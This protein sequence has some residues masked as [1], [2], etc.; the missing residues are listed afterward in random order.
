M[1]KRRR[2]ARLA[3]VTQLFHSG[4]I[5]I[6]PDRRRLGLAA[7]IAFVSGIFETVELYL[8][9]S[10]AVAVTSKKTMVKGHLGSL[11]WNLSIERTVL[12]GG[13]LLVALLLISVPLALLL[14]SLSSRSIVRMRTR[15]LA[16]YLAA[17]QRFRTTHREGL[18]Q[19]LIGEYCGRSETAVRQ[20]STF[21]VTL[22]MLAVV[23][24][25]AI[26]S[27]PLAAAG[28][29]VGL[30]LTS[31]VAAPLA[32]RAQKNARSVTTW[33]RAMSGQV[34]EMARLSE[35]IATFDV[36][37][38][39]SA[40]VTT[41]ITAGAE[42]L[43]RLRFDGRISPSLHLYGTLGVVLGL[44]AVFAAVSPSRLTGLAPLVLLLVRAL[45][46]V[47]QMLAATQGASEVAPFIEQIELELGALEQ[48]HQERDG[49][50][51]ARFAGLECRDVGFA[52]RNGHP[53]LEHVNLT[54]VAGE[55][56]GIVGASGSGKT[57]LA[58]LLL[59][60]LMPTE[61]MLASG[62]VPLP[63]V[64]PASW[65]AL[66]AFVPQ[67][68]KLIYGTV[69]DNIR[70]FRGGY[71]D[72]DVAGAARRAHLHGDIVALSEGYRTVIGPGARNLSGGQRQRLAIARALLSSPQLLVLDEPTSALDQH[73][74]ILISRTLHEL[75]GSMTIVLIAHRP[76]TIEICDRV[77]RV[78]DKAVAELS[79]TAE[80][81]G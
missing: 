56:V 23:L 11:S 16:A 44:I 48:H 32:R 12:F 63:E 66:S 54:I 31:A 50:E 37:E 53:V 17:E 76:A 22:C 57:S 80:R 46:Y 68:T 72:D 52:Y 21:C 24:V 14:A 65:A 7:L 30:A 77:F 74:E 35:E 20:L 9:A 49:V 60:Q 18:L 71:D 1:A 51:L 8:I 59:R 15:I 38:P 47:R 40:D 33:T 81:S 42:S 75:R 34:A 3:Y 67:D 29:F 64:S 19:Q 28:V 13:V 70:F 73:S 41:K 45:M 6:G 69:A 36:A 5:V 61:G 10:I 79:P 26:L 62:G 25:G 58:G 4:M 43:R 2:P 27:S 39:V 55:V 78:A